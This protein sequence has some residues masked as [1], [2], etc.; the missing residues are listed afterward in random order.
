MKIVVG[1][2][3]GGLMGWES[4]FSADPSGRTLHLT[5]AFAAHDGTV[6]ALCLDGYDNASL[7]S[8]G[9]DETIRV[10]NLKRHK[11]VGTL[12]EHKSAVTALAFFRGSHLLSGSADGAVCAWQVSEWLCLDSMRGHRCVHMRRILCAALS[13]Y[14][15]PL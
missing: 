4:D 7:V 1:T 15:R 5:Y 10:Y 9:S 11:E 12:L 8:G 3:D 6:R 2:Y 14:G 13:Q